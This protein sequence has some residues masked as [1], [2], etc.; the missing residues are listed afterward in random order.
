[1]SLNIGQMAAVSYPDVI[2]DNKKAANQWAE[3]TFMT[4]AEKLG[5]IDRRNFG[6]T[7]E[8]PLDYRRN[9]GAKFLATD[10]TPV[11]LAKTE[12]ITAASFSPAQLSVPVVWSKM[13]DVKNPSQNQKIA[14]VK[15]LLDNGIQSHDDL[16]EEACFTTSTDGFLGMA[17]IIPTTGQGTVGGIDAG[18]EVFWRNP[19]DTYL[20]DGSDIE[21]VLTELWNNATKGT[22][23]MAPKLLVSGAEANALFES[24][25]VSLKRFMSA[26]KADG[27]FES[28]SFKTAPFVFSQYGDDK[29]YG[30]NPRS[31]RIVVSKQYFRDK[32]ET[33]ET[34]DANGFVFKIYS[35]VQMITNNKSRLFVASEA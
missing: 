19:A 5:I 22:G 21:A 14:F 8:A 34:E 10:M 17:T 33:R 7:I 9:P 20:A 16:M 30:L 25:Q 4:F 23:G 1:M 3:S 13:D 2:A 27:G 24:T 6:D 12:V 32:G 29:I 28:V 35:A 15:G 31:F 18:T 11:S 26:S